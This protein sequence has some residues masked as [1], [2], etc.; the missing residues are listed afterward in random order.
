MGGLWLWAFARQ[1]RQRPLLPVGEPE[2]RER[3][4]AVHA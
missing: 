1:L 3:L 4:E 2:I